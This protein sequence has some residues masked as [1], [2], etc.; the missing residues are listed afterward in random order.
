MFDQVLSMNVLQQCFKEQ[1][2]KHRAVFLAMHEL[3]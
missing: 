2:N 3:V 1:K